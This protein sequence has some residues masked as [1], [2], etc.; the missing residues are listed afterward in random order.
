VIRATAEI[1]SAG[2]S[3][4]SEQMERARMIDEINESGFSQQVFVSNKNDSIPSS[5]KNNDES[6]TSVSDAHANAM[7]GTTSLEEFLA[8][9]NKN[10]PKLTDYKTKPELLIHENLFNNREAR[11]EKWRKKL[12]N[13]RRKFLSQKAAV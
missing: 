3:S 12:Q 7:F 2:K 13:D 1:S 9:Q 5:G 8:M 10:P 4:I 11:L 6:K